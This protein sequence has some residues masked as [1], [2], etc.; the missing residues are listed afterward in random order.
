MMSVI[1]L[2]SLAAMRIYQAT[3]HRTVFVFVVGPEGC[4][5]G[6]GGRSA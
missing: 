1:N 5:N 4:P 6:L 2:L 3:F